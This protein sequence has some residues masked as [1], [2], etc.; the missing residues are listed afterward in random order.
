MAQAFS[1]RFCIKGKN[2]FIS[3]KDPLS[4][5]KSNYRCE[6][7]YLDRAL[8]YAELT[9]LVTGACFPFVSGKSGD[10]PPCPSKCP[11]TGDWVKNQ[12]SP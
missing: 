11:G 1:E 3:R 10:V 12:C 5:D 6:G 8:K 7:G 2:V 4:C 9:G